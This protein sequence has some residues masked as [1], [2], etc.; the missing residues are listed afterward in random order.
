M[1]YTNSTISLF[2]SRAFLLIYPNCSKKSA[3]Q[4]LSVGFAV[5]DYVVDNGINFFDRAG[6]YSRWAE[7]NDG[8]VSESWIGGW[9]KVRQARDKVIMATKARG[10]MWE[11]EDGEVSSLKSTTLIY[12]NSSAWGNIW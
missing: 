10:R 9:L 2:T 12:V 4:S 1:G 7:G 3:N 8:G 11:G 6:V 5:M